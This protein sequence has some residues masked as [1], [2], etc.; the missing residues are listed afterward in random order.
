MVFDFCVLGAGLAGLSIADK[1]SEHNYKVAVIDP[2]GIASGASGVPLGMVNPATGRY[3]S[4]SWKGIECYNAILKTLERIQASTKTELYSQPGVI[5][6]AINEDFAK[7]MKAVHEETDWPE[8][9]CYWL[10][11]D[12]IAERFPGLKCVGGGIWLPI[13]LT[14]KMPQFLYAYSSMLQQQRVHFYTKQPYTLAQTGELW[15][16]YLADNTKVEAKNIITTAGS[17]SCNVEQWSYLPLHPIKGQ[18]II[19]KTKEPFPYSSTVYA[20]GYSTKFDS[21]SF[22]AGSTYEHDFTDEE[23]DSEGLERILGNLSIVLPDVKE[24]ILETKQWAGIRASTPNR[25]PILGRHPKFKNSYIF[26][27]LGS[28]GLLF[29]S[30]LA[31]QLFNYIEHSVPLHPR[32]DVARIRDLGIGN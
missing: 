7:K 28:K 5:R 24:S 8:G 11:K 3:A 23:P 18:I 9:W 2:N 17:K 20:S 22:A 1:L 19:L 13:D 29:S 4:K 27:G 14:V 15:T 25:L 30:Y 12:E 10:D 21:D 31:E 32:I 16:F 26:T 6:P